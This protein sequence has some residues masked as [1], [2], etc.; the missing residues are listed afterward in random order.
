MIAEFTC[1]QCH[2]TKQRHHFGT[3]KNGAHQ[4][5]C[6]D[7]HRAHNRKVR[8]QLRSGDPVTSNEATEAHR[9]RV[10]GD[11]RLKAAMLHARR[12]RASEA[13]AIVLGVV[14]TAGTAHPRYTP[15]RAMPSGL[16]ASPAA[17]CAALGGG[18]DR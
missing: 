9:A 14:K 2:E 3:R 11:L 6:R 7:C 17:E 5:W 10:D 18:V 12:R 13:H 4:P 16:G 8:E 15:H 1:T